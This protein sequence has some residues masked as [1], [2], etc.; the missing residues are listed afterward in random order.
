VLFVVTRGEGGKQRVSRC[1]KKKE[2]W[3]IYGR[4]GTKLSSS[5]PTERGKRE[6]GTLLG[7]AFAEKGR[8]TRSSLSDEK[9]KEFGT[10]G[11][12]KVLPAF[13]KITTHLGNEDKSRGESHHSSICEETPDRLPDQHWGR[14]GRRTFSQYQ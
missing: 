5:T 7:K 1:R 14:G 2:K 10:L 6:K 4:G 8:K 13:E 3:A 11:G 12:R 9:K